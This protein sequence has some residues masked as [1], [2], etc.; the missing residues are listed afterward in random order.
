MVEYVFWGALMDKK[1]IKTILNFI[2]ALKAPSK[3][4]PVIVSLVIT[5]VRR[6]AESDKAASVK[7]EG[8]G[9]VCRKSLGIAGGCGSPSVALQA[10]GKLAVVFACS[11]IVN[12]VAVY[13]L[14]IS[15]SENPQK[16]YA[17]KRIFLFDSPMQIGNVTATA[18]PYGLLI[19]WRTKI[20]S[21]LHIPS[22][23]AKEM[24]KALTERNAQLYSQLSAEEK[25][26]GTYYMLL[27][28]ASTSM[29]EIRKA[30]CNIT[31]GAIRISDNEYLWMG[32]CDGAA[33]AY[34]STDKCKT[35]ARCGSVPSLPGGRTVSQ[36]SCAKIKNGRIICIFSSQG[37][38]F[39][40]YSDD[41]GSRWSLPHMLNVSGTSPN[42]CVRGDGV[43][44]LSYVQ[45]EKKVSLRSKISLDGQY[46]WLEERALVISTADN[47]R[48]PY[49][50]EVNGKF[51]TVSRQRFAGERESSVVYTIW[52]PH[53]EDAKLIEEA[54]ET[55]KTTDR[56]KKR[57]K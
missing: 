54:A 42:L 35:F 17:S 6:F 15:R 32:E 28:D 24:A 37:E 10:D 8:Q 38:L 7:L 56:K 4:I 18:T 2:K 27:P 36:V 23:I 9:F 55:A 46:K 50:A 11:R 20:P 3:M 39:I 5:F 12:E 45:P 51:L 1:A 44:A 21:K 30:P 48:R 41:M 33:V 19:S 25:Q 29:Q 34:K 52:T 13:S 47:C 16:M 49:T 26:G 40:S 57:K 43:T 53:E 31:Q 22:G 14:C